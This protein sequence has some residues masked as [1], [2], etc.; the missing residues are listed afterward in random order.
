MSDKCISQNC[1]RKPDSSNNQNLCILCFDWFTKC[2][3]QSRPAQQP[4]NLENYQELSYIYNNLSNG[5]PV[6]S[7]VMM[8]ALLGSMMN[9]LNQNEQVIEIRQE[10][11]DLSNKVND[12]ET[13]LSE[14]KHK[15]FKLEYSFAELEQ[16]DEFSTKDTLVIR[17]APLS[18]D[19][20]DHA[21]ITKALAELHIEDFVPDDDV[22]KVM[23]KGNKNGKLGSLFVKLSD[24]SFEVKIMKKKKELI[25][26][27]DETLRKLK[28]M[29]YKSPEQILLENAL[30]KVLSVVPDGDRYE[31]NGNLHLVT[32]Q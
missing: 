15:L 6:D 28:I 23:R 17:N 3:E 16:K 8:K 31:L 25:N 20:D 9:L 14:S 22:L 11:S 24:E 13:E 32:K 12:L 4:K 26:H 21:V 30:R 27:G 1:N 7:N 10:I 5:I 18:E 2:Q 19:K 29:N